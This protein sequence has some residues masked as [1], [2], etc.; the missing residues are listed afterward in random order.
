MPPELVTFLFDRM[1][2]PELRAWLEA[3]PHCINGRNMFGE[4][5][6]FRAVNDL[7]SASLVLWLVERGVEVNAAD[8][9]GYTAIQYAHSMELFDALLESDADPTIR[10]TRASRC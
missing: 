2:E 5:C 7:E 10:M 6:L 8:D 4:T 9:A 3:N 1:A